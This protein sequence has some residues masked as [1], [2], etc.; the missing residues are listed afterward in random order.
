MTL[1]PVEGFGIRG[2]R[3]GTPHVG[4]PR[5]QYFI[6]GVLK[7]RWCRIRCVKYKKVARCIFVCRNGGIDNE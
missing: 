1:N 6:V 7:S 2:L 5:N 3:L 4:V